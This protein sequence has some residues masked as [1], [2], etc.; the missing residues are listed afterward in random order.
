MKTVVCFGASLTAGTVSANYSRCWRRGRRWP[1]FG[2]STTASTATSP[3]TASSAW[4]TSSPSEPD[5]VTILIGTNDVNATLSERNRARLPV[6]FQP[7]CPSTPTLGVV[8]GKPARHRRAAEA[9]DRG[10][11]RAH[12]ARPHRRGPRTRGLPENR[13][14]QRGHPPRRGRGEGRLSADL[15]ER[16]V[17]Y[18]ARARSRPRRS[19]RPGWPIATA[20]QHRQRHRAPRHGPDLGRSLAPQRAAPAHRL[21]PPQQHRRRA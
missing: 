2:S 17:A 10:A 16:M 18:L 7:A 15:H 5:F 12:L 19:F 14:L 8:R 13:P 9:R 3:G 21:P 11:N 4:T 1:V 20:S 6:Q